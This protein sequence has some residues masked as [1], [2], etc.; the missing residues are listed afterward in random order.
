MTDITINTP[1]TGDTQAH[2]DAMVA[3]ADGTPAP[4]AAPEGTPERPAW[5][6]EQFS[7]PEEMAAAYAA[8]TANPD[9]TSKETQAV[10]EEAAKEAVAAAGLDV[11]AL[12]AKIVATGTLD[13]A[14]FEALAKTGISKAMVESFVEGQRAIADR[15]VADMH[16]HVGGKDNF[17]AL[18]AW[19]GENL[20]PTEAEAFNGVVDTGTPAQ[21]QLALDGLNAKFR[22]A[23]QNA[24]KL[25]GGSRSGAGVQ[26]AFESSAQLTAA[27]RDPRY[28]TDPAFQAAVIARLEQSDLFG[29]IR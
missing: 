5:L 18:L 13:D 17:D 22:A 15:L 2:I 25:L 16:S 27:M 28:R 9:E 29:S 3:L 24:P 8:L 19:A 11:A 14:D 26:H 21:L 7:T 4:A 23:G 20:S 1:P 10:T 6:P 12:E